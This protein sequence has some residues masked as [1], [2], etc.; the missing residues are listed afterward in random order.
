[1]NVVIIILFLQ[2]CKEMIGLVDTRELLELWCDSGSEM[3]KNTQ[4]VD[5]NFKLCVIW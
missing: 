2:Y 1:M 4:N 5:Y 3:C